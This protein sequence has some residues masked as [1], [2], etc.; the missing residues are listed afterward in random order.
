MLLG[1]LPFCVQCSSFVCLV[2]LACKVIASFDTSAVI[3]R[4][5]FCALT[6]DHKLQ[7]QR[8]SRH[9]VLPLRLTNYIATTSI[10]HP[11][12]HPSPPLYHCVPVACCSQ[13]QIAIDVFRCKRVNCNTQGLHVNQF[14]W[15]KEHTHTLQAHT[16]LL[17]LSAHSIATTLALSDS[18]TPPCVLPLLLVNSSASF[19]KQQFPVH[20]YTSTVLPYRQQRYGAQ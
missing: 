4:L 5:L 10:T 9:E 13:I 14:L 17:L 12:I 8:L 6:F 19:Q 7:H 2:R 11:S 15:H 18:K 20:T 1:K 3:D 16:Q